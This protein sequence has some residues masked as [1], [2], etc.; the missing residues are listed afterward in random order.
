MTQ[1][2]THPNPLSPKEKLNVLRNHERFIFIEVKA[3][4]KRDSKP[5]SSQDREDRNPAHDRD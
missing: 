2:P 1:K 4:A 3:P 5:N